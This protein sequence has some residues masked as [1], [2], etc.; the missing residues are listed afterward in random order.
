MQSGTNPTDYVFVPLPAKLYAELV[1]RSEEADVSIWVEAAMENF[2]ERTEDNPEIWSA[3]YIEKFAEGQ[4]EAFQEKYG[5]PSRGYQWQA[6]F[7]PN[8]TQ[9]RMTYGGEDSYAE[10]RHGRLFYG[11]KNMSPSQFAGKVARYTNRNAWRDLYIK[12]PGEGA[13]KLADYIR[14]QNRRGGA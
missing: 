2:L 3:E 11:D 1:R 9:I 7:L 6:V 5:D 12:F 14:G 8:G 13:W 4:D 10:V